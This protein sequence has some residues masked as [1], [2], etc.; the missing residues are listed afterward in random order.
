MSVIFFVLCIYT[1]DK[2][3]TPEQKKQRIDMD[4]DEVHGVQWKPIA[5]SS[6]IEDDPECIPLPPFSFVLDRALRENQSHEV[7]DMV[8][9]KFSYTSR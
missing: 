9:R 7:W 2:F 8:S 3:K 6:Q 4:D 1:D 5:C